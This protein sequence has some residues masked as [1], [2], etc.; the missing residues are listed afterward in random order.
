MDLSLIVDEPLQVGLELVGVFVFA[1]S[2]ALLAIRKRFDIIGIAVLAVLT[3]LGG[4]VMRDVLIGAIP[5]AAFTDT[6][7]LSVALAAAVVASVAHPALERLRKAVL[8]FDAAGLGLFAVSGALK[9]VAFGLGPLQAVLLGATSAVGGG[10]LRDVVARDTP[11]LV[12]SDSTLYS[13]PALVGAGIVVATI[14][15]GVY[16][17]VIGL[18]VVAIVFGWRM[19]AL[20][21]GWRAPMA[22]GHGHAR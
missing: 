18:F 22:R 21:F 19:A 14:E 16:Q 6:R 10:L 4:G 12:R 5:P 2:G 17:P 11:V 9:A 13:V 20:R 7:L 8:V 1:V 3:A 15:T